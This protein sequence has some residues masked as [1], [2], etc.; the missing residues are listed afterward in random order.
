MKINK[1]LVLSVVRHHHFQFLLLF[2]CQVWFRLEKLW[3][4]AV[5]IAVSTAEI[6]VQSVFKN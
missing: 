3:P 6:L 4:A 2:N 1:Y 5:L